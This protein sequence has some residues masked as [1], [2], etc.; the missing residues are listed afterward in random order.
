MK[1]GRRYENLYFNK[2]TALS[3]FVSLL[4][5]Q[6]KIMKRKKKKQKYKNRSKI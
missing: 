6:L 4:A 1:K 2:N 3:I 5:E